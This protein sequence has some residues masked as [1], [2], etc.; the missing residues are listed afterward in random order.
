MTVLGFTFLA[1]AEMFGDARTLHS[2]RIQ[3]GQPMSIG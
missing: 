1:I 3:S 2:A